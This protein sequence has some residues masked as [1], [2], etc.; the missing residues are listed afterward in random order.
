MRIWKF[1]LKDIEERRLW[2][3]GMAAYPAP[4]A[5]ALEELEVGRRELEA[6]D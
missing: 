6:K 3:S 2:D 5:R 4:S 1:S